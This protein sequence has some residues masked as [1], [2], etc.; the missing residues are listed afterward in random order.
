MIWLLLLVL[1]SISAF[2]AEQPQLSLLLVCVVLLLTAVK[3]GLIVDYFM[4][5]RGAPRLWR[6]LMLA[7][8]PVVS[9]IIT[10]TYAIDFS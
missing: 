1:T 6:L 2:F 3:A 9:L 5:L 10:A 4:S 8:V 7:Y